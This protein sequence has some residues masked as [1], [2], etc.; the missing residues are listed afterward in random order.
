MERLARVM[1]RIAQRKG[2]ATIADVRRAKAAQPIL[3]N[4]EARTRLSHLGQLGRIAG[5]AR[6]NRYERSDIGDSHSNLH[7]V[8]RFP[9]SARRAA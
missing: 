3:T 4:K 1:R 2:T 5:L 6:T 9:S 8:W 7:R